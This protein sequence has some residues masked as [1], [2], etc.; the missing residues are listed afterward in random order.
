[1]DALP[2]GK[3]I[4][5]SAEAVLRG[6]HEEIGVALEIER[7]AVSYETFFDYNGVACHKAFFYLIKP[8][9]GKERIMTNNKLGKIGA[10]VTGAATA[11]FAISML[12]DLI[13]G[14]SMVFISQFVCMFIAFGFVAFMSAAAAKCQDKGRK[15]VG[16][17][18]VSFAA[19]Y[20]VLIF[21]VYYAGV[22]TL[23][24]DKSLS[25]ET[26]SIISYAHAGSLFFNYD[27]LGYGVMALSTFLMGFTIEPKRKGDGIFRL[28]LWIHGIFFPLCLVIPMIGV[29]K[30]GGNP[31]FGTLILEVWCVY[32]IPLC[33]L[34][35][36]YFKEKKAAIK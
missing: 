21:V 11:M 9:G 27:L 28:L 7:M 10:A 19:V 23:N 30:P 18:G 35:Y 2:E 29:F 16:M 26:L 14:V 31:L 8:K 36:R 32:F 6:V 25:T 4:Y 1:M 33:V 22:T 3:R 17:A 24:L 20:A 34:G 5:T 13:T 12:I 15:G